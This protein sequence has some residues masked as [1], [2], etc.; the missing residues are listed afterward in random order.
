MIAMDLTE[1]SRAQAKIDLDYANAR[2]VD[3][4]CKIDAAAS[5]LIMLRERYNSLL[6]AEAHMQP[7]V[8]TQQKNTQAEKK[9]DGFFGLFRKQLLCHVDEFCGQAVQTGKD[10]GRYTV[11]RRVTPVITVVGWAIPKNFPGYFDSVEVVLSGEKH[12]F[13]SRVVTFPRT[14]VAS[15]FGNPVLE[16]C[17]FHFQVSTSSLQPDSYVLELHGKAPWGQV[18][19]GRPIIFD[20]K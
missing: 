18:A 20:L 12:S 6:L 15:H 5:E 8:E 13:S 10:G 7:G 3:L 17:G 1:I 16:R 4:S 2:I 19:V 9:F 14:D 11:L